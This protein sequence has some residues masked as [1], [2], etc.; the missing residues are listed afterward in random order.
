MK[1]CKMLYRQGRAF[2]VKQSDLDWLKANPKA[3][4]FVKVEGS[5]HPEGEYR[6]PGPEAIHYIEQ[7]A[8][9]PTWSKY[10]YNTTYVVPPSLKSFFHGKET[11]PGNPSGG[12][13]G[14]PRQEVL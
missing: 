11:H 13:V 14:S 10:H 7:K 3:W 5:S 1:E 9:R 6:I 2:Y 12:L 4:L 8:K